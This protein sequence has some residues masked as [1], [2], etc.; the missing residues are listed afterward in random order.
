[1]VSRA[2]FRR[3]QRVLFP[4]R[5]RVRAQAGGAYETLELVERQMGERGVR[6]QV[7][8]AACRFRRI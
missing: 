6:I 1:M 3:V 2:A 5:W 7:R 4:G 8:V